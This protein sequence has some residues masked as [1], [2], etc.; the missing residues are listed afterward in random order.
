VLGFITYKRNAPIDKQL[1]NAPEGVYMLRVQ[2]T[3][4]HQVGTLLPDETRTTSSAQLYVFN[5]DM[6]A[7]VNIWL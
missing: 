1:E 4:F 2:G 6:E 7:Q 3:I 5:S